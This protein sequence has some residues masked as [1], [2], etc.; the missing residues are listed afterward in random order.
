[1]KPGTA[2]LVE[3]MT[4]QQREEFEERAAIIE[5]E[6]GLDKDTAEYVAVVT[7]LNIQ[8]PQKEMQWLTKA[9]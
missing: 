4:K 6:G 3:R 5:Y 9:P 7:T 2:I 1:M 8:L